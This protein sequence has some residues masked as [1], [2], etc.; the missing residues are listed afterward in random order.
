MC[1]MISDKHC[2]M[3]RKRCVR[4]YEPAA[5]IQAIPSEAAREHALDF[6]STSVRGRALNCHG[7]IGSPGR[8][9]VKMAARHMHTRGHGD[10]RSSRI[11][12]RCF[13]LRSIANFDRHITL[14]KTQTALI[15]RAP[16]VPDDR[17]ADFRPPRDFRGCLSFSAEC[18]R[19]GCLLLL[20]ELTQGFVN[21]LVDRRRLVGFQPAAG[22]LVCLVLG[23]FAAFGFPLFK[24]IA[25]ADV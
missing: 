12:I 13:L 11:K 7:A 17:V 25:V 22:D 19:H 10:L 8:D 1:H 2:R 15:P 3:A 5:G 14:D 20:D 9:K 21:S 6:R 16:N 23:A 4:K 18:V 24:R